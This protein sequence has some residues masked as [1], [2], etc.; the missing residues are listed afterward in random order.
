VPSPSFYD[1][2][3]AAVNDLLEHGYAD[4]G[5][6]IEWQ[7]RLTEAVDR[8]WGSEREAVERLRESLKRRFNLLVERDGLLREHRLADRFTYLMI[9]PKLRGELDRRLVAATDLIKLNRDEA[10]ARMGRRWTGWAT[11]LPVGGP[12]EA[13]RRKLKEEVKRPL[14]RL[15]FAERRLFIDQGAKLVAAVH[16]TVAL[17][18]GALAGRWRH[19]HQHGYDGRPEHV[20]LDGRY[21]LVRG[22]WALQ[23]GLIVPLDDGGPRFTDEVDRP[24]EKPFCRCSYVYEYRLRQ[25]PPTMLTQAGRDAL[26]RARE[27]AA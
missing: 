24:A 16:E 14:Q 22:S 12:A 10:V 11:S 21:L 13:D 4:P 6:V 1:V 15:P 17:D 7:R 23:R 27:L 2:L 26:S 8:S 20:A 25:L 5:Q 18:G 9:K 3:T 19:V